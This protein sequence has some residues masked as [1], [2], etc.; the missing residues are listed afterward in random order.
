[1]HPLILLVFSLNGV[2]PI[3]QTASMYCVVN[4]TQSSTHMGNAALMQ[5]QSQYVQAEVGS[6]RTV[7]MAAISTGN[8]ASMMTV[9]KG[10]TIGERRLQ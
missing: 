6:S 2:A 8:A 7:P 4:T 10:A 1:M 3:P 5:T 9:Q